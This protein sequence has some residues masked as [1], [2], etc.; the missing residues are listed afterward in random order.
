MRWRQCGRRDTSR[1]S[2]ADEQ[3]REGAHAVP[4]AEHGKAFHPRTQGADGAVKGKL[5]FVLRRVR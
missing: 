4:E 2:G 1:T 5:G 3:V